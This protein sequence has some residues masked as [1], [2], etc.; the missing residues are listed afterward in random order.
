MFISKKLVFTKVLLIPILLIINSLVFA[1]E[2]AA[3]SQ[4]DSGRFNEQLDAGRFPVERESLITP[5]STS[6]RIQVPITPEN[7]I[8]NA[9]KTSFK[10]KKVKIIGS[11]LVPREEIEKIYQAK[12]NKRI[13]IATL[14]SIV[15]KVTVLYRNE[16]YVLSQAFLPPQEIDK[17]IVTIRIIEGYIFNVKIE[18]ECNKFTQGLLEK[19]GQHIQAEKPLHIDTL[20]RYALLAK[21]IPGVKV[22]T[23]LKASKNMQGATDLVFVVNRS[24]T[25]QSFLIDNRGTKL[26][27]PVRMIVSFQFNELMP[28]G[29]T[30]VRIL[31]TKDFR[32]VRY[33]E[34][35]HQQQLN[36]HGLTWDIEYSDTKSAPDLKELGISGVNS[37]GDSLRFNTGF[38]YPLIRTR[39][40]N[41]KFLFNFR[42][43]ES[44]N[45]LNE[46]IAFKDVIRAFQLS[47]VY[48]RADPYGANVVSINMDQGLDMLGASNK[49]PS[50][51]GFTK[52]FNKIGGAFTRY[53]TLFGPFGVL[54]STIGQY[55][56]DQLP[57][58]E[59]FGV[60]GS[61]FG[62]AYDSSEIT[63]DHGIAW[64]AELQMIIPM[65]RTE[66]FVSPPTIFAYIDGGKVWNI[67]DSQKGIPDRLASGGGGFKIKLTKYI[68]T[69]LVVAKPLSK[70]LSVSDKR[71]ARVFFSVMASF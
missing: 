64:K 42:A 39:E 26:L 29:K 65:K 5:K 70:R 31:R 58:I 22:R 24:I 18:G 47:A 66:I 56:F 54:I 10:L 35:F 69:S 67:N 28:G 71:T 36:S 9:E 55:S 45:R 68:D 40:Q 44:V 38:S 46:T 27:G 25:S 60:G 19:Y 33:Y 34:L 63:G 62:L 20:E 13:T 59:E 57:S 6:V 12:L 8:P 50:R 53:Q 61:I 41:L 1:A 51:A 32:E 2:P 48:D 52:T 17:G 14:Q 37:R 43:T 49:R 16:G 11:D 4:L 15:Q 3:R 23:I 21:D 7:K 30:G